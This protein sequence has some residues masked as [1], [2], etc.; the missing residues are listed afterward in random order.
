MEV[1]ELQIVQVESQ[2][3]QHQAQRE[4][5]TLVLHFTLVSLCFA[6]AFVS[7]APQPLKGILKPLWCTKG[8]AEAKQKEN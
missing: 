1:I 4:C 5:F 8:E 3:E 7:L 6:F 2:Q